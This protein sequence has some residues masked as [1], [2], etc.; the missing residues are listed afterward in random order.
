MKLRS[1]AL[2]IFTFVMLAVPALATSD[3]ISTRS[4]ASPSTEY[5]WTDL[6]NLSVDQAKSGTYQ[7][8]YV[9]VKKGLIT[10]C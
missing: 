10:H 7:H 8:V 6:T 9:G 2:A 1:I 5:S 3:K 4:S